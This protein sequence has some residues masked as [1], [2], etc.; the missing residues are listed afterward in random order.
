MIALTSSR[1]NAAQIALAEAIRERVVN[2]LRGDSEGR[3]QLY[4]L[5]KNA[6]PLFW[7]S[8]FGTRREAEQAMGRGTIVLGDPTA[9]ADTRW[10]L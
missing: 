6:D 9:P 2:G 5:L 4:G 3:R 8:R 1:C 10:A 7:I